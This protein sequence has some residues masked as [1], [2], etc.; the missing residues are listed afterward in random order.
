MPID[1]NSSDAELIGQQLDMIIDVLRSL[2]NA[3]KNRGG[4]SPGSSGA[5]EAG[6]SI[7]GSVTSALAPVLKMLSV[8]AGLLFV[9]VGLT[10]SFVSALQPALVEQFGR[11]LNDLQATIGVAFTGIFEQAIGLFRSVSAA[12]LPVFQALKP[13]VDELVSTVLAVLKSSMATVTPILLAVVPLLR[14]VA[15]VL[16]LLVAVMQP[17]I[18]AFNLVTQVLTSVIGSVLNILVAAIEPFVKLIEAFANGLQDVLNLFSV[19]LR[20]LFDMFNDFVK[21]FAGTEFQDL[22]KQVTDAFRELLKAIVI[23]A[24]KLSMLAGNT[25]FAQRLRDALNAQGQTA[26]GQ[27]SLKSLEQIGKDLALASTNAAGTSTSKDATNADIVKTLDKLIEANKTN[28]D[29]LISAL[30]RSAVGD[31]ATGILKAGLGVPGYANDSGK[32]STLRVLFDPLNIT[33]G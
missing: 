31:G 2:L 26:A 14:L 33:G 28:N 17:V 30:S 8:F 7:A 4:G 1:E 29:S 12:L 13:V 20:V 18:T 19:M 15:D 9:V 3:T 22:I 27:T 32:R 5:A 21:S 11:A 24:V 25:N 16:G 23:A 6:T 10:Q